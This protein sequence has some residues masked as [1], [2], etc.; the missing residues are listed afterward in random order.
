VEVG[1]L[2]EFFEDEANR[3]K[4]T[5]GVVCIVALLIMF[6]IVLPL[7][8]QK[9]SEPRNIKLTIK[10]VDSSGEPLNN[11]EVTVTA[12]GEKETKTTTT[13][14]TITL[15]V[16]AKS[17][18]R[19]TIKAGTYK[20]REFQG[21]TKEFF[22]GE[23]DVTRT[24][25]LY[26]KP[27]YIKNKTLLFETE[28]GLLKGVPIKASLK[29]ANLA[30][31]PWELTDTD[32]DGR[33]SVEM[34][35]NCGELYVYANV[36]GYE[37]A[38]AT[39]EEEE[40]QKTILLKKILPPKG[41]LI[42]Y[43]E[44]V[45]GKP[46]IGIDVFVTLYDEHK[47]LINQK[48]SNGFSS[49]SFEDLLPGTYSISVSDP[50]GTYAP[51]ENISFTIQS[52]SETSV[53]VRLSKI[54]KGT[55]KVL[56][57][58][59]NTSK[60]IKDAIVILKDANDNVLEIK[61]SLG[62]V[63]L[64]FP[65]SEEGLYRITAKKDGNIGE[66]YFPKTVETRDLNALLTIELEPL[67]ES[68]VGRVRV[69]VVDDENNAVAGAKVFF[70]YAKT[71]T[72]VELNNLENYKLTDT[73]GVAEFMLGEIKEPIYPY[74][75]K[76]PAIGGDANQAKIPA[77]RE[78]TEFLVVL[79]VGY[80]TLEV[81][82]V[83]EEGNIV[84][85]GKATYEVY[86]T[87]GNR[88]GNYP[89]P[90]GTDT[91]KLRAGKKI[92]VAVKHPDYAPYFSE[93]VQ[94]W[95]DKKTTIVALLKRPLQGEAPVIKLKSIEGSDGTAIALQAGQS[96]TATF[97][98][99]FP[100]N[101]RFSSGGMHFREGERGSLEEDPVEILWLEGSNIYHIK[102]GLTYNPP[103]GER[104]EHLTT[105]AAKWINAEWRTPESGTYVV[106]ARLRV[107]ENVPPQSR[108]VLYY[109]AWGVS[110][111]RVWR[112][113]YDEE[114][115]TH[116]STPRKDGL[117]ASAY[118]IEFSEGINPE[119]EESDGAEVCVVGE[120]LYSITEEL[121]I[122]K[123]YEVIVGAD[124]NYS[125]VLLNNS[126]SDYSNTK[127]KL[128]YDARALDFN[129][130]T[131]RDVTGH[132]SEEREGKGIMEVELRK[133]SAR[134]TISLSATFTT[135]TTQDTNFKI[136]LVYNGR[137]ILERIVTIRVLPSKPIN[138]TIEPPRIL[139][140]E[141]TELQVTL[142]D[143]DNIPISEALIRLT[144]EEPDKEENILTKESNEEG[145]ASF[146]MPSLLPGTRIKIEAE[147][148]GFA[149]SET[150]IIIDENFVTIS[151]E[152]L[153]S[154]L[155]TRSRTE[156]SL[157]GEV[158]NL[159]GTTLTISTM[160]I[161]GNFEGLLAEEDMQRYLDLQGPITVERESSEKYLVKT[162]LQPHAEEIM[163]GPATLEG[164]V[165]LTITEP[166]GREYPFTVPLTVEVKLGSLEEVLDDSPCIIVT[167]PDIP[168]WKRTVFG[169][170]VTTEFEILNNCTS[171]E[172]PIALENL[173]AKLEWEDNVAGIVELT[174]SNSEGESVTLKMASGRWERLFNRVEA[175]E[176]FY[177]TVTFSPNKGALNKIAKFKITFDGEIK[178]DTGNKF[179][180]ADKALNAELLISN[181]AS[182]VKVD[183]GGK[184]SVRIGPNEEQTS[185]S[186]DVSGCGDLAIRL[187]LCR[188]DPMCKGGTVEGGI[189]VDPLS[190]TF[191][192]GD[193]NKTVYVNR[194][195]IPGLYTIDI[196]A[197]TADVPVQRVKSVDIIVEPKEHEPFYLDRYLADVSE[198]AGWT[199]A[200]VAH[201]R[202]LQEEVEVTATL[203]TKCKNPNKPP[204]ECTWNWSALRMQAEGRFPLDLEKGLPIFTLAAGGC[205]SI[206]HPVG[207]ALCLAIA[208]G[209]GIYIS[210]LGPS[211]EMNPNYTIPLPD[212]VLRISAP[213][214]SVAL[215]TTKIAADI[216]RDDVAVD[217]EKN[218]EIVGIQFS[219][220]AR[221]EGEPIFAILT[222]RATEHIHGDATHKNPKVHAD[223]P[224]IG[225]YNVPDTETRKVT[226][227]F[228]M[229]FKRRSLDVNELFE[230]QDSLNAVGCSIGNMS[231]ITGEKAV[232]KLLMTWNWNEIPWNACDEEGL[233]YYCDA[234][235]FSIALSK[236]IR[237]F[238]EF[239]RM[240]GYEL[241]C[242]ANPFEKSVPPK[243]SDVRSVSQGR[244]GVENMSASVTG[245]T[246]EVEGSV[247]NNSGEP[248]SCIVKVY[249]STAGYTRECTK[250]IN[251][252]AGASATFRCNFYDVPSTRAPISISGI[253]ESCSPNNTADGHPIELVTYN[254]QESGR[255]W[256][257]R[258]TALINGRPGIEYYINPNVEVVKG[259]VGNIQLRWP[260]GWPGNT[261][262]EKRAWVSK[263]LHFDALLMKDGFS[264]DFRNDFVEYYT[265]KSFMG[266]PSWFVGERGLQKY[267]QDTSRM[268]FLR[269]YTGD[270]TINSPGKYRVDVNIYYGESWQLFEGS[271][272]SAYITVKFAKREGPAVDSPFYYMPFDGLVGFD[273]PNGRE[274]YGTTF[275]GDTIKI[276]N[277]SPQIETSPAPA[278][279]LVEVSTKLEQDMEKL[280]GNIETRGL[281]L[282]ARYQGRN[283]SLEFA[284]NLATPVFMEV[285]TN[286]AQPFSVEYAILDK[287][288]LVDAG[289]TL[290]IWRGLGQGCLNFNGEPAY[291]LQ[292]FFDRK[293]SS[294]TYELTWE[295]VVKPGKMY[296]V[297]TIFTPITK[298]LVLKAQ[299]SR[300]RV[301]SPNTGFGDRVA[302]N[303]IRTMA[304]NSNV[305]PV[306]TIQDVLEL[307]K[308]EKVCVAGSGDT[309]TFWWNEDVLYS[310]SGGNRSV[311][312]LD[313]SLQPG[314]DC[315]GS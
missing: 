252:S 190:L 273:S 79:H 287:D 117:Y 44:D 187:E 9:P 220:V 95:P 298:E 66:G 141:A 236:R 275:S 201:S 206:G 137:I 161:R 308:E 49:V 230:R 243:P 304:Y 23:K 144:I 38:N 151:P 226:K 282:K 210:T 289:T 247:R 169:N 74:V 92:Y 202:M 69:T 89:L 290:A 312:E 296:L 231:G 277:S 67:T 28:E 70:R 63:P 167:G 177:A 256:I 7:L 20:G 246:L 291:T 11:V 97:E 241:P 65:V 15:N 315:I 8:F 159:S 142:Q 156:E 200:V 197:S 281:L 271:E 306:T 211:C 245:G 301:A 56:V 86:S 19:V 51:S 124:Y 217:T 130:L 126:D 115:G 207:V 14:G 153:R 269:R 52:D 242:P 60:P 195:D 192:P 155:N 250:N 36:D 150:E 223:S 16:P 108:I 148:I 122:N 25:T 204:E 233:G 305:S 160:S 285:Q 24:I 45:S 166:A 10:V 87:D 189:L 112:D 143:D 105:G 173:K 48:K 31:Q 62:D 239:L 2:R 164:E 266:T 253:V 225:P 59:A 132:V 193:S 283:A 84:A 185:F 232:P 229:K 64:K 286:E 215:D 224:N 222:I 120:Y 257:P 29:C 140:F 134:K 57:I 32:R 270:S 35:P 30:I 129:L 184:E 165:T 175:E 279:A 163:D 309:M 183:A 26:E 136:L 188:N 80:T 314:K 55:L 212:Y 39:V 1:A 5:L 244:A 37:P 284:P 297:S 53:R 172:Q 22:V 139:P 263:L 208:T 145:K 93:V 110:S 61:R 264:E 113:P 12:K 6:F 127:V 238:D 218:E 125:I 72:I 135:K 76:Y 94:L 259:L 41:S 219:N 194:Q 77:L 13:D 299:S 209:I 90:A 17:K 162:I 186:I 18:V 311:Q 170:S 128:E 174:V 181:L 58:D 78:V 118:A 43:I 50:S 123:P 213:D 154:I 293:T 288:K 121:Y 91:I 147:K 146:E 199:D 307:V 81:I 265:Q 237:M 310:T 294:R 116:E 278:Q 158:E 227:K 216:M 73:N 240:N 42:V 4:V 276:N 261:E 228:H 34:P 111:G 27:S 260:E 119:C 83:D 258:T 54:F 191:Q 179:V 196:Y 168:Q 300:I 85:D 262:Q 33:I 171:N 114:L 280:N 214:S 182:C 198:S 267:F 133:F 178:T 180:G 221:E 103:K 107:K 100:E 102:K 40:A 268:K 303:G 138:I 234:T 302:L 68:N 152:H 3:K 47:L 251:I 254:Y 248:V 295:S 176:T 99:T 313:A 106:K 203:C 292:G 157:E 96:Y 131:A 104:S 82:A 46:L 274:G 149:P 109:R 101:K 88:L 98:V 272:P 255:C 205:P 75:I 71:N 249:T 21:T 235:Q